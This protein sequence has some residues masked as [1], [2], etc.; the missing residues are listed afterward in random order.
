MRGAPVAATGGCA[1]PQR[2]PQHTHARPCAPAR[3][4]DTAAASA[5]DATAD[6]ALT[7]SLGEQQRLAWARLLLAAPQLALLD[8]ASSA[9]DT[10]V[11][12]ELYQVR[13]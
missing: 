12:A 11:E 10:E 6:W 5:L 1:L 8:E 9:L 7:L 2:P 4:G 13:V 3:A